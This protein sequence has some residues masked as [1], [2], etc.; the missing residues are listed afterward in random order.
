VVAAAAVVAAATRAEKMVVE[1]I[2]TITAIDAAIEIRRS[3]R[4]L[5]VIFVDVFLLVT[6]AAISLVY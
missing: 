6:Y 1:V 2:V 4:T 5:I 3:T